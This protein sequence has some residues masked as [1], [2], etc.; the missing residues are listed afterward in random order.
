M[1]QEDEC[2]K[3]RAEPERFCLNRGEAL[4]HSEQHPA[5]GRVSGGA[6]ITHRVSGHS[7]SV[8][9]GSSSSSRPFLNFSLKFFSCSSM[10]FRAF[11]PATFICVTRAK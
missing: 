4:T 2:T 7:S 6:E 8:L 5:H 3:S 1:L 9:T 10:D 11:C